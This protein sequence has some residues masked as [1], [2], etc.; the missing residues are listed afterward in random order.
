MTDDID[1]PLKKH[2]KPVYNR[3]TGE[4]QEAAPE[5]DSNAWWA[6]AVK[7]QSVNAKRAAK[8]KKEM[9]DRDLE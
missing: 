6:K 4:H 9:A 3:S 1:R 5:M 7:G 8:L 2:K